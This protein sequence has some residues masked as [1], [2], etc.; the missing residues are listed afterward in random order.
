MF[1][2]VRQSLP[3]LADDLAGRNCRTSTAR[4]PTQNAVG[5]F[6]AALAVDHT[7]KTKTVYI[8]DNRGT[9]LSLIPTAR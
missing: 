4:A 2:R 8:I 9:D 6:Q 3:A 5:N 1:T 7:N